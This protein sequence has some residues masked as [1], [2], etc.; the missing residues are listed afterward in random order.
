MARSVVRSCRGYLLNGLIADGLCV[1]F[2]LNYDA[3]IIPIGNYIGALVATLRSNSR[4][5]SGSAQ[6]LCA[7]TLEISSIGHGREF[8]KGG[9]LLSRYCE[10]C[11][12]KIRDRSSI[13][14][15]GETLVRIE[16]GF[17]FLPDEAI[18]L[19]C[20]FLHL[21]RSI[22]ICPYKLHPRYC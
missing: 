16:G 18:F 22:G 6:F 1:K 21:W 2:A 15:K 8:S 3:N 11:V 19:F 14:I 9:S 7:E 20:P 13:A 4:A 17:N 5:P 10:A 12:D